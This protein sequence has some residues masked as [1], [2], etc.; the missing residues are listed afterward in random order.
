V[1]VAPTVKFVTRGLMVTPVTGITRVAKAGVAVITSMNS[2]AIN[3]SN[4]RFKTAFPIIH[5]PPFNY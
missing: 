3:N 4:P 2:M 1:D 5:L